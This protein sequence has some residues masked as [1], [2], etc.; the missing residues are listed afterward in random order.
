MVARVVGIATALDESSLKTLFLN[1]DHELS[2]LFKKSM[3]IAASDRKGVTSKSPSSCSTVMSLSTLCWSSANWNLS[4][5]SDRLSEDSFL[6]R[7]YL[8]LEDAAD[9]TL[10]SAGP[11]PVA[12]SRESR[13]SCTGSY[14]SA[15]L[16]YPSSSL[17]LASISGDKRLFTTVKHGVHSF[18]SSLTSLSLIVS[19]SF[20]SALLNPCRSR[21]GVRSS[22]SYSTSSG[23]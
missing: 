4:K 13:Y 15:A 9:T 19:F 10:D 17:I 6:M 2:S 16:S 21:S 12:A 20:T 11:L 5:K 18:L 7:E 23:T 1:S 8:S 3:A 14:V 22:S